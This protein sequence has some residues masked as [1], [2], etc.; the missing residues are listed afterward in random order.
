MPVLE[1][2]FNKYM[3][4]IDLLTHLLGVIS[5]FEHNDW[6]SS[7]LFSQSSVRKSHHSTGAEDGGV[8]KSGQS[9]GQ[10]SRQRYAEV[11]TDRHTQTYTTK[12]VASPL[13]CVCFS[14]YKKARADIKKKSSDTIKLQK[15]MKKGKT[16]LPSSSNIHH[17][18][19]LRQTQSEAK[20]GWSSAC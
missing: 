18:A 7:P 6:S 20:R 9:A 15:K 5:G 2:I 16:E 14:E 11:L 8:E 12:N 17:S 10:R 1:W 19:A 3:Y 13:A 4:C